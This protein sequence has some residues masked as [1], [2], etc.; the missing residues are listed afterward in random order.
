LFHQFLV[1][2]FT[3][4]DFEF[5][6]LIFG[7]L[8]ELIYPPIKSTLS[9][10]NVEP[11]TAQFFIHVDLV[12]K[13]VSE[14]FVGEEKHLNIVELQRETG[15]SP[16]PDLVDFFA[17]A[18]QVMV[19]FRATHRRFHAQVKNLLALVFWDPSVPMT[20]KIFRQVFVLVDPVKNKDWFRKLWERFKS[21]TNLSASG[22]SAQ[23]LTAQM[24]IRFCS[25]F[26]MV[27]D[28]ILRLP[29]LHDFNVRIEHLPFT[30]SGLITF[31]VKRYTEVV[32]AVYQEVPPDM[33][34][35]L[36]GPMLTIRNALIRCDLSTALHGYRKFLQQ[37]DV[38]MTQERP[39]FEL[40]SDL[41]STDADNIMMRLSARESLALSW[42]P[43]NAALLKQVHARQM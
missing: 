38:L 22:R 11:E 33:K 5:F 39:F 1:R 27:A 28:G 13:F 26:P 6:N 14:I 31:I 43:E 7:P 36:E 24:F 8:S 34:D 23:P 9:D 3:I 37:V 30:V 19:T 18:S 20:E 4:I 42:F 12:R 35:T 29:Y 15:N 16:H 2:E 41:A 10:P 17:F 40:P 25:D 21:E 32:Y